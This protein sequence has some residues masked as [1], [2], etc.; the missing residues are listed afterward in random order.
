MPRRPGQH[1]AGDA[2]IIMLPP[3]EPAYRFIIGAPFSVEL[4]RLLTVGAQPRKMQAVDVTIHIPDDFATRFGTA[5]DLPRRV[6]GG[7]RDRGV[8]I[9]ASH[10]A[11][12]APS[13][14]IGDPSSAGRVPQ[15]S[16]GLLLVHRRRPE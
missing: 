13:A 16:R 1:G 9:G 10:P 11:G 7:T 6:L 2:E 12:I 15:G 8:P 5:R 14:W 4:L 3:G